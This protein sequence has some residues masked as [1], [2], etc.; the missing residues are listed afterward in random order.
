MQEVRETWK[1]RVNV[2]LGRG[3]RGWRVRGAYDLRALRGKARA[4]KE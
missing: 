2:R 1:I 3:V 4:E